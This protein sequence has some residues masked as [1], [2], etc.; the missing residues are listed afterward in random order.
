MSWYRRAG[1]SIERGSLDDEWES[2]VRHFLTQD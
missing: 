2:L 1:R